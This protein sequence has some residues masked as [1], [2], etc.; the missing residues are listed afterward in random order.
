MQNV[1]VMKE[2]R[3]RSRNVG[4]LHGGDTEGLGHT[5]TQIQTWLICLFPGRCVEWTQD[6][7]YPEENMQIVVLCHSLRQKKKM[8][9][10]FLP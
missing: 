4:R 2:L 10:C 1:E 8:T 9:L 3:S 7:P 6:L 5:H